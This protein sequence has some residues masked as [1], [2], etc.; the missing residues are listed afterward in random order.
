MISTNVSRD[1]AHFSGHA[2]N[3]FGKE[4]VKKVESKNTINAEARSQPVTAGG[5]STDQA[6]K[7]HLI[8]S[9]APGY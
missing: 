6:V 1:Q 7:I 9:L 2:H 4:A 5:S 3:L 8:P